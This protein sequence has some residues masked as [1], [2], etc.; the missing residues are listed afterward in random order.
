MSKKG[1]QEIIRII[2]KALDVTEP[3]TI[4]SSALSIAEW[5]SLGQINIIVALDE[6][7][8]GGVSELEEMALA[9]SVQRIIDI[10]RSVNKVA[11]A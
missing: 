2:Q 1:E 7:C 9:S 6:A 3:V 5:D 10:L 11:E 8:G 4:T